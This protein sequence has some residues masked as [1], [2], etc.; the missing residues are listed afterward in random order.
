MIAA[1][2]NVRSAIQIYQQ[3]KTVQ[4]ESR[5]EYAHCPITTMTAGRGKRMVLQN[6]DIN[7]LPSVHN[8][9]LSECHVSA[10]SCYL[11]FHYLI[12]FNED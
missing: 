10:T 8:L 2:E 12:V 6:I 11:T 3:S 5:M 1:N 4:E 7:L 9:T